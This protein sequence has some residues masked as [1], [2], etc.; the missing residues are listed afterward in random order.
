MREAI[1][2]LADALGVDFCAMKAVI[3]VETQGKPFLP[4]GRPVILFEGHIFWKQLRN[5]GIDPNTF[6]RAKY[7]NVLYPTW[8]RSQYKGGAREYERL[9]LAETIDKEAALMSASYGLFQIM[10]FNYAKCGAPSVEV[11]VEQ[12]ADIDTQFAFAANFLRNDGHIPALQKRDWAAFARRYNGAGY[13][14]N[15]YDVKLKAAYDKCKAR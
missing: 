3:D 11:F 10:G 13:A 12:Q 6:S 5:K 7:S 2:E 1:Q 15:K 4:D 8:D 14:A 9:A